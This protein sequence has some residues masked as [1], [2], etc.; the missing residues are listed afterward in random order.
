MDKQETIADI[1]AEKRRIAKEVRDNASNGD[2]WDKKEANETAEDLDEE[3]DRLEAAYKRETDALKQRVN[4]L[5]AEIAAKDEV[6]MRLNDA[7]VEEQKRSGRYGDAARERGDCAKLR[8]ALENSNG[9][10]E[11]LANIGEWGE[12]AKEQ[13]AENNAALSKPIRNCDVGTTE[14]QSARFDKFCHANIN[15][16]RCCGD[17]PAFRTTRDDCELVL[18]QLP[19]EE[20]GAK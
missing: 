20:G 3:A 2:Y 1:A 5:D 10:L 17:C 18:A 7:L 9:L 15:T 11:E 13:I 8:E 12:S 19:Y 4:E 14:E 6:I 16:E